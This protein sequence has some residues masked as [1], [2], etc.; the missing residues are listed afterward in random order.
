MIKLLRLDDRLIHGQIAT[1]W[2][3]VLSTDR[4]IVINDK[5]ANNEIVK[6]SLLMAAPQNCKV[7]IKGIEDAI[8]LLENP[9]AKEH[10]ILLIVDCPEDLKEVALRV[11]GIEKIN[12]GN[13]GVLERDSNIPRKKF[14][15]YFWYSEEEKKI[16]EEIINTGVECVVQIIPDEAPE[17]LKKILD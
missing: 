3:R 2:S 4:I 15:D 12:I 16:Y 8:K 5:A 11:S 17:N 1:K 10:N 14:N 9:K 6:K 7:A 13:F